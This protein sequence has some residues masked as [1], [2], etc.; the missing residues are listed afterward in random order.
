MTPEKR[1]QLE[2]KLH[3]V[4]DELSDIAERQRALNIERDEA[5]GDRNVILIE[6]GRI[7]IDNWDVT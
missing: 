7:G 2:T 1:E 6:L 4:Y 5:E 3:A